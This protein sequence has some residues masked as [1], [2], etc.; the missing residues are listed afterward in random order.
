MGAISGIGVLLWPI[1]QY[2]NYTCPFDDSEEWDWTTYTPDAVIML[3]GPNDPSTRSHF[4][5][6]F[7]TAYTELMAQIADKYADA[8]VKP[9]IISVC[10]GS[11]NGLDP[12]PNIQIAIANYNADDDNNFTA[13]YTTIV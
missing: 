11:I 10:G 2:L 1:Q 12:C 9:K 7:I 4:E 3:I 6:K 5:D 8:E 13:Y